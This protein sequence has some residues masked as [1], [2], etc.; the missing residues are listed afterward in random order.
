MVKTQVKI[1][2]FVVIENNKPEENKTNI[3]EKTNDLFS[4]LSSKIAQN[5]S[6]SC[7]KVSQK[8]KEQI[9]SEKK[10]EKNI[11]CSHQ[12]LTNKVSEVREKANNYVNSVC[13]EEKKK[14]EN[15]DYNHIFDTIKSISNKT[16]EIVK[17]LSN[18]VD[19]NLQQFCDYT[20]E[21]LKNK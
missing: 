1:E 7:N 9:S 16:T 5:V 8:V 6:D 19:K 13:K 17:N 18:I 4:N 12:N 11:P 20:Y 21:S 14:K 3:F 10:M 15:D 2:D